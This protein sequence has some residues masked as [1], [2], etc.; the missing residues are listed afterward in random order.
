MKIPN[1]SGAMKEIKERNKKLLVADCSADRWAVVK[2][3]ERGRILKDQGESKLVRHVEEA[4]AEHR[5]REHPISKAVPKS[6]L[7]V[8]RGVPVWTKTPSERCQPIRHKQDL[9]GP[10]ALGSGFRSVRPCRKT[11]WQEVTLTR[12][13]PIGEVHWFV[14]ITGTVY[15]KI[16]NSFT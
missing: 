3:M 16:E 14:T 2:E 6:A 11:F 8:R 15:G 1:W 7:S 5:K 13:R 10:L 4:V 9:L 12:L